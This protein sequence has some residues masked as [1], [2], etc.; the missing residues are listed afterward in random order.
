MASAR[1]AGLYSYLAK[2]ECPIGKK[3]TLTLMIQLPLSA[4]LDFMESHVPNGK[5]VAYSKSSD[6]DSS[7][8]VRCVPSST[9]MQLQ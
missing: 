8:R 7:S 1:P 9:R 6:V 2:K 5:I 3:K 4:E